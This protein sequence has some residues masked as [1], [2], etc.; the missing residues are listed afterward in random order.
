MAAQPKD[1]E[2]TRRAY[3]ERRKLPVRL[4]DIEGGEFMVRSL[5]DLGAYRQD[6]MGN[7]TG[8]TWTEVLAFCQMSDLIETKQEARLLKNMSDAWCRGYYTG[9]NALGIEPVDQKGDFTEN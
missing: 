7:I 4:P 8:Q 9:C 2:E 3:L 6:E 5:N 1:W